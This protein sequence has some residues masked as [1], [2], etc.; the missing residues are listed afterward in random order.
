MA[1]RIISRRGKQKEKSLWKEEGKTI[2]SN[3]L[4]DI[5][6]KL[7]IILELKATLMNGSGSLKNLVFFTNQYE[8]ERINLT[9]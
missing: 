4:C 7:K 6:R 5:Y 1:P 9:K 3:Q 8:C 2:T